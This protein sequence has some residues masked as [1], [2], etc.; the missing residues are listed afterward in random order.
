[1]EFSNKDLR[2][3]QAALSCAVELY[4]RDAKA[5]AQ[6]EGPQGRIVRQYEQQAQAADELYERIADETGLC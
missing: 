1:M 6:I 4:K 2:T 5:C 3:V